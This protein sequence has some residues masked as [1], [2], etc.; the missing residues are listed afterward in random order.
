[1]S[2]NDHPTGSVVSQRSEGQIAYEDPALSRRRQICHEKRIVSRRITR[3]SP[4]RTSCST[5]PSCCAS[6]TGSPPPSRAQYTRPSQPPV[7]TRPSSVSASCSTPNS[8]CPSSTD[9]PPCSRAVHPAVLTAGHYAPVACQRQ[10]LN[11]EF[12]LRHRHRLPALQ[13]RSTPSRPDRRS[14]RARRLSGPAAKHPITALVLREPH[15]LPVLQPRAVHPAVVTTAHYA[16]VTCQGDLRYRVGVL[17]ELPTSSCN[18]QERDQRSVSWAS[19]NWAD[20]S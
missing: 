13:P 8:C 9:S 1:V 14:L 5:P 6:S 10:L 15:R 18:S 17:D 12:V 11:S 16:P 3:P 19:T 7:T 2:G 4:V 20:N